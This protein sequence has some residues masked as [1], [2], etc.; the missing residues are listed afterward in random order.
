MV[1]LG[2]E[3]DGAVLI[4]NDADWVE[5]FVLF[6][7]SA[8]DDVHRFGIASLRADQILGQL[9]GGFPVGII[10]NEDHRAIPLLIVSLFGFQLLDK[11][12]DW[13]GARGDEAE[14]DAVF[15]AL[16]HQALQGLTIDQCLIDIDV[17]VLVGAGH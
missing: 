9:L 16:R 15:A 12:V 7:E 10:G 5:A 17:A 6:G 8:E 14:Y 11:V 13:L 4:H 2:E 1:A 3:A